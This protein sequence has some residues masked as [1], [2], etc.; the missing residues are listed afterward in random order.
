MVLMK[1]RIKMRSLDQHTCSCPQQ[2]QIHPGETSLSVGI[3]VQPAVLKTYA[4]LHK[5][6]QQTLRRAGAP[7]FV[8]AAMDVSSTSSQACQ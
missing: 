2:H 1:L 7:P 4:S 3:L 8:Y 5:E 6:L